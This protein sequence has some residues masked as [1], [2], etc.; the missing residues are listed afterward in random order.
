MVGDGI[1]D[2]PALTIVDVSI[3]IGSGSD[4]A[5]SSAEFVLMSSRLTSLLALI[6]LS[7]TVFRRVRFNFAW[8]LVYNLV[9]LPVAAGA[10]YPLK[11]NGTHI[12]LDP[13]WASLAMA[14]SSISVVCSSLLLK[15]KL[16]GVGFR[17][18]KIPQKA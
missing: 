15:S 14:L 7:R 9:A 11:S 16:P 3:A 6:D 12:R 5:I 13:V 4:V 17:T 1:N 18:A 10:L 2:A 8:A